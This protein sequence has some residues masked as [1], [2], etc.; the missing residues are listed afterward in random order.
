MNRPLWAAA[1]AALA[2]TAALGF[3]S[4]LVAPRSLRI[5]RRAVAL[6]R[7]PA[8]FHDYRIVHLS[9]LHLGALSSGAE[10][11]LLAASL[12]ADLFV[13]TG[14][15]I[16]REALAEP[17]ARLLGS[18]TARDGVVCVLGNH[19]HAAGHGA[20]RRLTD[21]LRQQGVKMLINESMVIERDGERLWLVGVDDPY[22]YRADLS[23]AFTEVPE[24]A[25]SILLAHSPDIFIDLPR[26]RADLVLTG[27]CHGG[28]VRTPWGPVFTR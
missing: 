28:Q 22:G 18:L 4:M 19:D 10:Q 6:P 20:G 7:L 17:C 16:E 27:H 9:D 26:G 21:L 14:D 3:H 1:A 24:H 15:M 13:V 5:H 8:A 12:R 2:G 23:R 25:P 11:V